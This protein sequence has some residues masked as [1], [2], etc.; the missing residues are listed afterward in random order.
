MYWYGNSLKPL[1]WNS[2]IWKS[3]NIFF[4]TL[5]NLKN[6][7]KEIILVYLPAPTSTLN[8]KDPI[9]FQKYFSDNH[10]HSVTKEELEILSK[11]IRLKIKNFSIK[12]GIQVKNCYKVV[13]M[14]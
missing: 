1:N 6:D 14:E 9:Y 2:S 7:S 12:Q 11:Y 13:L 10:Q 5:I 8:L 3:L 4:E